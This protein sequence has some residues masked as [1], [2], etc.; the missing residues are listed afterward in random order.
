MG[1]RFPG[2]IGDTPGQPGGRP[3]WGGRLHRQADKAL[4]VDEDF[5]LIRIIRDDEAEAPGAIEEL[6][7]AAQL[8]LRGLVV[9]VAGRARPARLGFGGRRQIGA[10]VV[11]CHGFLL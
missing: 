9:I 5:A 7:R 4:G 6:D 3:Q 8:R 1:N 10:A 11:S 2:S